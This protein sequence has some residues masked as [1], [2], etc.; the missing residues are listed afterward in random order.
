[1]KT[2]HWQIV[3]QVDGQV[4]RLSSST[5]I[6]HEQVWDKVQVRVENRVEAQIGHPMY[7]QVF[8]E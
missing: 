2:V 4:A 7:D 1:M 5:P 3:G 8:F 6:D